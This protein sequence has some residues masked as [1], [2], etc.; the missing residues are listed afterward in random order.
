MLYLVDANVLMSAA[1]TYYRH[2]WVPEFWEWLS[3][4]AQAGSIKVPLEIFEEFED[5]SK[6][7]FKDQ[8]YAWI[9]DPNNKQAILLPQAADIALVQ[10]VLSKGYSSQLTEDQV[11]KLGR[12]PF[13]IAH[14]LTSPK[15]RCVV[16][17]EKSAP[18]AKPHNRK[19]PDAC[20]LNG[21]KWCSPFDLMA[22]LKFRTAWKGG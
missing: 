19:I 4:H 7:E 1:N 9:Q 21:V 13:L 8:M 20:S 11:E 10:A 18:A 3:F 16:T 14:A 2:D 17:N 6:D 22:A 5:G 15:D 12:D